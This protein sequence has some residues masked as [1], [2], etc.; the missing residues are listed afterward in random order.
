MPAGG[1]SDS[2]LFSVEANADESAREHSLSPSDGERVRV[3]G[4]LRA[5][6]INPGLAGLNHAAPGRFTTTSIS[7][8]FLAIM[9]AGKMQRQFTPR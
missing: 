4:W 8:L 7:A 5:G 9:S 3:R 1:F 2:S 6:S